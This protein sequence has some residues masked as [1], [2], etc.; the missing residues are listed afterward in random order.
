MNKVYVTS[1]CLV[2]NQIKT[3]IGSGVD[4]N[5]DWLVDEPPAI[6]SDNVFTLD[7]SNSGGI[8]NA[9]VDCELPMLIV[10]SQTKTM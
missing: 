3:F 5:L 7:D 10:N 9:K 6:E 1:L 4:I 2:K 8:A